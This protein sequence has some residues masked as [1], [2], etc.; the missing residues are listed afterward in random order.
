MTLE[1]TTAPA[2]ALAW[3]RAIIRMREFALIGVILVFAVIMT[4][5]SPVFLTAD[6]LEALLLGLSVEGLI[7]IGM[8]LVMITGGF[9][10]SVGSTLAFVGVVAALLLSA[11]TPTV[12]A[13]VVALIAAIAVGFANGYLIAKLNIN[14]FLVTLGMMLALRGLLLVLAGGST[15]LNLPQSFNVIGQ[16][17]IAGLQTPIWITLIILLSGDF[18]V[19]NLK[20]FR[21]S[22]YVGGNAKAAGLSG[23]NVARVQIANYCIVAVLAGIAGLLLT[24]RFGAASV[25][26]GDGTELRVI[27][28]AIIGGATL[29][30]GEG[31]VFGAFLGAL[32]MG[33]V[34]NALNLLGVNSYWQN[35]ATGVILI[36]AVLI[37]VLGRKRQGGHV[38][39]TRN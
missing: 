22:Y 23:I 21:Q 16:G 39:H 12:L 11:G 36:V 33:M 37:D 28:A 18:A 4:I 27:T 5:A 14:A 35:L 25:T 3:S 24:A 8:V 31:T 1:S 19:R 20:F 15:V 17:T 38:R 10:L 6:N 32:F 2:K 9:D 34:A 26:V 13:I 29:S 7:V 30:G